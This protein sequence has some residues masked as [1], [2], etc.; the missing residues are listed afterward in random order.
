MT[1]QL[2]SMR[3]ERD[4][5]EH[6]AAV[7]TRPWW[8]VPGEESREVTRA[9]NMANT[10]VTRDREVSSCTPLSVLPVS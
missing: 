8:N 6:G 9:G 3:Y 5:R 4:I 10:D 7:T 1:E 2:R